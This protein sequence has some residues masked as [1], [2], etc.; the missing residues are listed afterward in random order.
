[1]MAARTVGDLLASVE[2]YGP[3]R[4]ACL[5]VGPPKSVDGPTVRVALRRQ[6]TMPTEAQALLDAIPEEWFASAWKEAVRVGRRH[7][8]TAGIA[9]R[10]RQPEPPTPELPEWPEV[11]R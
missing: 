2:D 8:L 3:R 10:L 1:M 4:F 9:A 11:R 6:P 5:V 7:L